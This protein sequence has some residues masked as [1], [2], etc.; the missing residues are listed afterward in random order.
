MHLAHQAERQGQGVQPFQPVL[1]GGHVVAHLTE[2]GGAPVHGRAGLGGQQFAQGSLGSLDA[3]GQNSLL[4]YEGT[5]Q[6][7]GVGHPPPLAG[8]QPGRRKKG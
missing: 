6:E 5:H 4:A 2:V 1:Q 7:V 3:A 8:Q